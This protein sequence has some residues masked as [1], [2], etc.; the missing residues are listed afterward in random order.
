MLPLPALMVFDFDKVT[1]P[2]FTFHDF[3]TRILACFNLATCTVV[4]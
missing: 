3:E 2:H 1:E 4:R